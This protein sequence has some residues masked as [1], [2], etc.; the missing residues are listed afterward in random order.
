[1]RCGAV[2]VA[3]DAC[4]P[5]RTRGFAHSRISFRR[6]LAPQRR[7]QRIPMADPGLK[8]RVEPSNKCL[9]AA[10]RPRAWCAA[11]RSATSHC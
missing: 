1:L 10:L 11:T 6:K 8:A 9:L 7:R 2:V 3:E 4:P 5:A